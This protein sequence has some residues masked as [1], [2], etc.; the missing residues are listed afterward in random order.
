MDV[1]AFDAG[2]IV[3]SALGIFALYFSVIA[4]SLMAMARPATTGCTHKLKTILFAFSLILGFFSAPSF[5]VIDS[6]A[7]I[8][9]GYCFMAGYNCGNVSVASILILY[10]FFRF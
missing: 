2:K 1:P 5:A 3:R 8:V 7:P 9:N 10:T 4:V 6:V